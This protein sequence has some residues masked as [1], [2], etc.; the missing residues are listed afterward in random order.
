MWTGERGDATVNHWVYDYLGLLRSAVLRTF[1]QDFSRHRAAMGLS[2]TAMIKQSLLK[3]LLG[4]TDSPAKYRP[5]EFIE[6]GFAERIGLAEIRGSRLPPSS[7]SN[8]ARRQRYQLI[9]SSM[10]VRHSVV[11]ERTHALHGL[12]YLDPWSDRRLAEFIISIPQH[13]V[14]RFTDFKRLPR[15]ALSDLM[16]P[17]LVAHADSLSKANPT[18]LFHRGIY[19]REVEVVRSL[20][21]N[22]AAEQLRMVSGERLSNYYE[23]VLSGGAERYDPWWYITLEIWLRKFF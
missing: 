20:I 14:H 1:F 18:P 19:E 9:F 10:S 22:S 13:L 8:S 17:N 12:A 2:R 16:P 6:S 15:R 5:P 21:R 11:S 3:P 4:R 23:S 7:I